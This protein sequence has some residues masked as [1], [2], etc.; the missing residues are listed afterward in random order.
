MLE[1]QILLLAFGQQH[2]AA[3]SDPFSPISCSIFHYKDADSHLK[4]SKFIIPKFLLLTSS[5]DIKLLMRLICTRI[6]MQI[7]MLT[8]ERAYFKIFNKQLQPLAPP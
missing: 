8:K 4:L 6:L 5:L 1:T 3:V 2:K 7:P